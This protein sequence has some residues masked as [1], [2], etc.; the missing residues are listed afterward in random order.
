M[1]I[2][3]IETNLDFTSGLSDRA[4]TDYIALHHAQAEKCSVYDIHSWHKSNGWAGIGYHFLV[5]K[6]GGI[7]R[8]RPL[9]KMGAHVSGMNNRSIGICAEGDFTR[10]SMGGTQK[11]AVCA[12]LKYLKDNFYPAAAIVGHGEIGSSDCPGRNYPLEDIK[13]NYEKYASAAE[14]YTEIN[15][16]I[17]ELAHRGIISDKEM[18]LKKCAGNSNI[19][20]LCRK[21]CG[22]I[23]TKTGG[24]SAAYEYTGIE[25]ILWD[26]QYRGVISDTE[27]WRNMSEKDVNV[28]YLLKKGLHYMRTH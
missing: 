1:G 20:W 17:W 8:G 11:T 5:R 24:E 16:I 26:L 22:Y 21:M 9:G 10:E 7:Y 15:D 2:E 28:Y 6:D 25:E 4:R 18:W 19:Y 14:E 23:R 3:I 27:L 12:L 13:R